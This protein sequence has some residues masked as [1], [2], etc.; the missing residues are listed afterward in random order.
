M[1]AGEW[2]VLDRR[3]TPLERSSTPEDIARAIGRNNP[4]TVKVIYKRARDR[5]LQC[6]RDKLDGYETFF[7]A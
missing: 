5:V 1:V 4:T 7:E 3:L 6:L 2:V